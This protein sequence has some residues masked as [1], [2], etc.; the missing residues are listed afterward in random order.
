LVMRKPE[1][2]G[3]RGLVKKGLLS[4]LLEFLHGPTESDIGGLGAPRDVSSSQQG[5]KTRTRVDTPY[6]R[7]DA[8]REMHAE[9]EIAKC[10]RPEQ[11]AY[12]FN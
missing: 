11:Y 5:A 8:A 6:I 2:I 12:R 4:R 9:L 3:S 1:R 10:R 7:A